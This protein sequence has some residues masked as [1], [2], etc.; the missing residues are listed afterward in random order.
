MYTFAEATYTPSHWSFRPFLTLNFPQQKKIN[1]CNKQTYLEANLKLP[2]NK[3]FRP[4]N[5]VTSITGVNHRH[6]YI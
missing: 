1:L 6:G 2:L 4:S 5:K 3:R